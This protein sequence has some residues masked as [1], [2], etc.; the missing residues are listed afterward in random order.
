LKEIF[1]LESEFQY[2]GSEAIKAL[3]RREASKKDQY[4]LIFMDLNM[5]EINGI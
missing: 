2:S 3:K 1:N 4:K 5:P